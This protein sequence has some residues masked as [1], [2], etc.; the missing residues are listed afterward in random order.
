MHPEYCRYSSTCCWFTLNI[1]LGNFESICFSSI[2]SEIKKRITSM[3]KPLSYACTLKQSGAKQY[4]Q[5]KCALCVTEDAA[6]RTG[7]SWSTHTHTQQDVTA[8]E[9]ESK[10]QPGQRRGAEAHQSFSLTHTLN[11]ICLDQNPNPLSTAMQT[12]DSNPPYL[13]INR[14]SLRGASLYVVMYVLLVG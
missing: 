1:Y 9:P 5:G 14:N 10:D 11:P 8:W 6:C 4:G 2:R 7:W 12:A 3:N 13:C